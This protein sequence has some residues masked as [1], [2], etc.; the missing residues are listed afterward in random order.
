MT[1]RGSPLLRPIV[2]TSKAG[3]PR[4]FPPILPKLSSARPCGRVHELELQVAGH[5]PDA[6]EPG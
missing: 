3:I 5:G 4:R 2:V 6:T 1:L